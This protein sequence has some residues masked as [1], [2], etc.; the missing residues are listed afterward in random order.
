MTDQP[1]T[2]LIPSSEET[3]KDLRDIALGKKKPDLPGFTPS[4]S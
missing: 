3:L 2:V 1:P 4:A